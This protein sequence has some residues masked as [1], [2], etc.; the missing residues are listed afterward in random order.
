VDVLDIVGAI[1]NAQTIASGGYP[2]AA[3]VGEG[4]WQGHWRKKKGIARVRLGDGSI[5]TAE[6]HG[7]EAHGIGRKEARI[8]QFY[9]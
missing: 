8:E 1:V 2:R 4:V 3:P 5:H 9:W 6:V 7:Y